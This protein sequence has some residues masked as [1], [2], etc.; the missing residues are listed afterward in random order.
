MYNLP[1]ATAAST[2]NFTRLLAFIAGS[3]LLSAVTWANIDHGHLTGSSAYLAAFTALGICV[4]ALTIQHVSSK[5]LAATFCLA[6]VA[7]EGSNLIQIAERNVTARDAI[8][9]TVTSGNDAGAAARQRALAADAALAAHRTRAS[10]LVATKSCADACRTLLQAQDAALA[11]DVAAARKSVSEATVT[12]SANPLAAR[13]GVQPWVLDLVSALI[14]SVAVNG[15]AFALIC[16]S[17]H[18]NPT[19]IGTARIIDPAANVPLPANEAP[20][21]TVA[22][23]PAVPPMPVQGGDQVRV[24]ATTRGVLKLIASSG[25]TLNGTQRDLANRLGV[26]PTTLNRCLSEARS[27]GLIDMQSDRLT[28]TRVTMVMA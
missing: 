19:A 5:A 18:G 8:A 23:V 26:P 6:L 17:S 10:E 14:A 21:G 24:S 15:L 9:A 4:A 12:R 11:T 7:G 22:D 28:G 16:F 3:G 13:L 20:G 1:N 2:P 27:A 25:G